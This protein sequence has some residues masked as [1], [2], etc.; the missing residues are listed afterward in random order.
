MFSQSEIIIYCSQTP[1]GFLQETNNSF[2]GARN[3]KP[4]QFEPSYQRAL[5]PFPC[6]E[7]LSVLSYGDIFPLRYLEHFEKALFC[8]LLILLMDCIMK[9]LDCVVI[10]Q[11]SSATVQ[12][13]I[14]SGQ[15][16]KDW[17]RVQDHG[18]RK[19]RKEVVAGKQDAAF[20][21]W[22]SFSDLPGD[23]ITGASFWRNKKSTS[24]GFGFH[25]IIPSSVLPCVGSEVDVDM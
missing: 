19:W 8:S 1:T 18:G 14:T 6:G 11:Q 15:E 23:I 12:T 21:L 3:W 17:G 5:F 2:H 9:S 13:K 10:T 7:S 16:G 24:Q 22:A 25:L 20:V 4:S